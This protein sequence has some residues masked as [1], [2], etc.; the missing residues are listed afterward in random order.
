MGIGS[1]AGV[2]RRSPMGVIAAAS[3]EYPQEWSTADLTP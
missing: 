2:Q 1:V 3:H